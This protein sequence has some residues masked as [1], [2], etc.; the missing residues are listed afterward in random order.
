M[1]GGVPVIISTKKENDF[2][3]TVEELSN[4]ITSKTKAIVLSY[5]NNPTGACLRHEDLESISDLLKD[6]DIIVIS[7]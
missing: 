1:I 6:K 5:P 3:V 4:A 2:R 7:D